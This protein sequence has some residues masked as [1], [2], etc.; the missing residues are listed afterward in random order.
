[1]SVVT[2][3]RCKDPLDAQQVRVLG[4]LRRHGEAELLVVLGDGSKRIIPLSWTDAQ[5]AGECDQAATLGGLGDL[6]A[7]CVLVAALSGGGQ[8]QAARQSPCKEDDHAAVQ[9]S[10]LPEQDPVP[11]PQALGHLPEAETA[12]AIRL[13]AALIAKAAAVEEGAGDE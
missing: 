1:M 2:I 5:P 11:V 9:L 6:L 8:G 4:R 3:T 13:L 7:A 12:E 10:L